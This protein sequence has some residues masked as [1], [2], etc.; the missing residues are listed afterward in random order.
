MSHGFLV[1]YNNSYG[2]L[3][4]YFRDVQKTCIC[5]T[6]YRRYFNITIYRTDEHS[7]NRK[8]ETKN[9]ELLSRRTRDKRREKNS[10][11]FLQTYLTVSLILTQQE[12]LQTNLPHEPEDDA[13]DDGQ[14]SLN[15]SFLSVSLSWP[16]NVREEQRSKRIQGS[17]SHSTSGSGT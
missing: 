5:Q 10:T 8:P 6:A 17:C 9:Y 4:N 3:T 16:I 1:D 14:I 13:G 15:R 11:F 12:Y 2:Q 7:L